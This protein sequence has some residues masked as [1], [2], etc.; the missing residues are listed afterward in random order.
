MNANC[1]WLSAPGFVIERGQFCATCLQITSFKHV[2]LAPRQRS[3]RCISVCA[4]SQA[5]QSSSAFAS[6]RVKPTELECSWSGD[7][8]SSILSFS[9]V[10]AAAVS[11]GPP[12]QLKCS[13]CISPVSSSSPRSLHQKVSRVFVCV[14]VCVLQAESCR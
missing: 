12:A 14:G 10:T 4:G 2:Q 9:I 13:S 6:E 1:A 8:R 3:Q 5:A 11:A 7:I